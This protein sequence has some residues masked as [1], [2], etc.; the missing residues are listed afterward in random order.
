MCHII[1][2]IRVKW[3]VNGFAVHFI[4]IYEV[5]EVNAGTQRSLRWNYHHLPL[6][7]HLICEAARKNPWNIIADKCK[8][9]AWIIYNVMNDSVGKLLCS[10]GGSNGNDDD[11]WISF[12]CLDACTLISNRFQLVVERQMSLSVFEPIRGAA[13]GKIFRFTETL[14]R[15]GLRD[16]V[17]FIDSSQIEANVIGT[18]ELWLVFDRSFSSFLLSLQLWVYNWRHRR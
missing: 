12:G 3:F 18:N 2:C 15:F 1:A 10:G 9:E 11:C 13:R 14:H 7:R 6:Y 4:V 8:W 16:D 17:T 5:L